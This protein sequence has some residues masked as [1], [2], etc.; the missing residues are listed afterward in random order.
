MEGKAFKSKIQVTVEV[1]KFILVFESFYSRMSTFL[2]RLSCLFI[3]HSSLPSQHSAVPH[4]SPSCCLLFILCISGSSCDNSVTLVRRC[5]L[6][7]RWLS[8]MASCHFLVVL[9]CTFLRLEISFYVAE[10]LRG[11]M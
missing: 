9:K 7:T 5:S 11:K 2:I 6:A 4:F 3:H 8:H 1:A 10:C